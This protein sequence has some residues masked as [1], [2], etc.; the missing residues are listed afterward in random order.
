MFSTL[1]LPFLKPEM[2]GK[3]LILVLLHLSLP[4]HLLASSSLFC[5]LLACSLFSLPLF[6]KHQIQ[7][8]YESFVKVRRGDKH[9]FAQVNGDFF[10]SLNKEGMIR[11]I[12]LYFLFLA[13]NERSLGIEKDTFP[14]P[15]IHVCLGC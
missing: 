6:L 3:V 8:G 4:I 14:K 12:E 2:K 5:S 7:A 1:S 15:S 10:S 13:I 11:G 9:S